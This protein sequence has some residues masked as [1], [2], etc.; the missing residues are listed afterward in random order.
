MQRS[1]L[2]NRRSFLKSSVLSAAALATA[3]LP[4]LA[5]GDPWHGLKLGVAS[6]SFRKFTLD[7]AIAM[8][9]EL[10]LKYIC[11]KDMHLSLKATA[12][13]CK[14]ALKKVTD[15]GLT[16][17]GGGV[18]SWKNDPKQIRSIFEYAKNAGMPTIVCSPDPD[19]IDETEK[20]VKEF[21]I[22]VAI[23]NHGPTDKKYPAPQDA[24]KLIKNRDKRM[25]L[26]I[27]VGHTV[28]IGVD[29]VAA[30]HQCA[31]RLYDFHL[32]DVNQAT[33]K[34]VPVMLGDGVINLLDVLKALIA[35]KFSGH[36]GLEYEVKADEKAPLPGMKQGLEHLR[37]IMAALA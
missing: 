20:L 7:E 27:D 23:H 33:P 37:K 32:K 30:I 19:A 4:A 6:Y 24:L 35:V 16:M 12:D 2:F 15:A 34:G 1:D 14:A 28:R 22:K 21:D 29:A 13:E 3:G 8:T 11:L 25:G 36:L 18:I 9:K 10:G 26:C 31:D 17:M 5:A